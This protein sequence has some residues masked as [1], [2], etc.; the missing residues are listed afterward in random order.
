QPL[1]RPI[2]S[3]GVDA[4]IIDSTAMP[5]IELTRLAIAMTASSRPSVLGPSGID[6][7]ATT[8]R[9][10]IDVEMTYHFFGVSVM[11]TAGAHSHL[12]HCDRS[13][14]PVSSAPSEIDRPWR[15][16]R[17]VRATEMKPLSAPNGT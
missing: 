13:D 5:T 6:A 16:A 2:S 8:P 9:P 4:A 12:S 1:T 17:N 15:V 11:S 7:I 3:G 14:A 10:D